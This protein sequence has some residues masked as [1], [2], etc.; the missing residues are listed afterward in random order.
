MLIQ[1][2][3]VEHQLKPLTVDTLE[4]G[5]DLCPGALG[6]VN[7]KLLPYS[8]RGGA[9]LELVFLIVRLLFVFASY[10]IDKFADLG[11]HTESGV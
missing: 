11:D 1:N 9:S 2:D 6:V 5:S 10:M 7:T 3:V 4:P 8:I